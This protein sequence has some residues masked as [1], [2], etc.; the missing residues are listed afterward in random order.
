MNDDPDEGCGNHPRR[1]EQLYRQ[2]RHQ[3]G[4][5]RSQ[6]RGCMVLEVSHRFDGRLK[7]PQACLQTYKPCCLE[8]ATAIR[9]LIQKKS[10]CDVTESRSLLFASKTAVMDPG[11]HEPMAN[12]LAA[13]PVV[14]SPRYGP[15][16]C[17][18]WVKKALDT[19]DEYWFI[20]LVTSMD[21]IEDELAKYLEGLS[22]QRRREIGKMPGSKA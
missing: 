11:F 22:S 20:K 15:L 7:G 3:S 10:N 14:S 4:G 17:R 12:I 21:G 13:V 6:L 9:V 19:L 18:V 1:T 16:S 5:L 2:Y 8:S